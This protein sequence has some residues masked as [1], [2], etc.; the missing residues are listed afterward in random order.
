[1]FVLPTLTRPS[2][3]AAPFGIN[4]F[5]NIPPISGPP[6]ICDEMREVK[7]KELWKLA[8]KLPNDTTQPTRDVK[9]TLFGRRRNVALTS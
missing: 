7:S 2:F 5:T 3:S 8:K 9:T 1:V 6:Y 4:A